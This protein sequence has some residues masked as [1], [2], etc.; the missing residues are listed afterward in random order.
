MG[1]DDD[2][3][4]DDEQVAA[5]LDDLETVADRALTPD[6]VQALKRALFEEPAVFSE[7]L[8]S[9]HS[10]FVKLQHRRRAAARKRQETP[11]RATAG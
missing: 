7:I 2:E 9:D 11:H 6:D 10:Y 3:A 8:Y 1:S 4:G 5:I